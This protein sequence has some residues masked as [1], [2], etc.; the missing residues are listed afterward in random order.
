MGASPATAPLDTTTL[1]TT[2]DNAAVAGLT[3]PG[4]NLPGLNPAGLN[5]HERPL[6]PGAPVGGRSAAPG[7]RAAATSARRREPGRDRFVDA[8]RAVAT[9]GIVAL[10]WLMPEAAWDGQT[11]WIGNA[12]GHGHAWTL[13]WVLQTLPLLFFAA[14]A[15][16]GYQHARLA[17]GEGWGRVLGSRLLRV[18]RP[19][20]AF[21]AAWVVA[22]A[23]LL[24]AGV[25]DGAVWRL[26]RI[27]PQLLWF[28]GV[29]VALV[30][31]AP[32]LAAAWRRWQGRA[33][34]V[35]VAAPLA[36]DLLRFGMGIEGLGWA[37]VLLVWS[38]PFLLGIAYANPGAD[39]DANPA[40]NPAAD[41]DAYRGAA[42]CAVGFAGTSRA[43]LAVLAVAA[44]GAMVALVALGPYPA[45][46]VGMPGD[47]I[48][49]LSPPTAPVLAQSLAQVAL[50]LLARAV[51]T[52]WALGRGR[53]LV[54]SLAR[55]SMT[56]YLWHL[57]AM[58]A[59]LGAVM[60]GLGEQPPVPWSTDWWSTRPVWFGAFG[61]TLLGLVRV[62]GRFEARRTPAVRQSASRTTTRVGPRNGGRPGAR[63][64]E[65]APRQRPTPLR[66]SPP[67]RS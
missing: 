13:T 33:V 3:Q 65:R 29:W 31:L 30:A 10:H 48:S 45:S 64:D 4:L 53:R 60:L 21:L 49:N 66:T 58:F 24:A 63:D 19:V 6:T 38:A 36:V 51:L 62:F 15:S 56:V 8:V 42:S 34:L 20:G 57:T 54:D 50:A 22:V 23:V 37:N 52:R 11:L 59:V 18:A 1:D 55:R 44:V 32:V 39:S 26:A 46:M 67:G 25:P 43:R 40:A 9:L 47:A 2:T 12:L 5:P 27:A 35:V 16:A 41:P 61:L 28:L 17:R 7:T 14:G